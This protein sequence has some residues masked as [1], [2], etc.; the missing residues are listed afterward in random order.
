MHFIY[1]E[2]ISSIVAESDYSVR[3]WNSDRCLR[4]C[5]DNDNLQ[6]FS[7]T[8]V[9]C[10]ISC[11]KIIFIQEIIKFYTSFHIALTYHPFI[12]INH[13]VHK[14]NEICIQYAF[15]CNFHEL[16]SLVW[17]FSLNLK[18]NSHLHLIIH[19]NFFNLFIKI[20]KVFRLKSNYC[21]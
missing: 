17:M 10:L 4:N 5:T 15:S 19:L 21:T 8:E 14:Y 13:F 12:S 6:Y 18:F 1:K 20:M 11:L 2:Q 9:F 7:N 16:L 3:F